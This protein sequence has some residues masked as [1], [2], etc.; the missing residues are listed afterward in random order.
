[1]FRIFLKLMDKVSRTTEHFRIFSLIYLKKYFLLT[2]F[3]IFQ[4][5]SVTWFPTF[6]YATIFKHFH[7]NFL[8]FFL[9][10][11]LMLWHFILLVLFFSKTQR[12]SVLY[13]V[14][15]LN[16]TFDPFLWSLSQVFWLCQ[17]FCTFFGHLCL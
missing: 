17:K 8:H 14:V 5:A 12:E 9:M 13:L 1:M 7:N 11:I 16:F 3:S 4:T 15:F 10:W 6:I 2:L